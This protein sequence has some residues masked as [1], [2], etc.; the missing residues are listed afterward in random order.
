M[1]FFKHFTDNH[2]GRTVQR[3]LDEMGPAG[4]MAYYFIME[5]CAEKLEKKD[6]KA[7]TESDCVFVFNRRVIENVTRMKRKSTDKLGIIGQECSVWEWKP[8]QN[9]IIIKMPILLDLL[10]RDLKSART[11]R[12]RDAENPRLELELES[13][14][15][16]DKEICAVSPPP[17]PSIKILEI[18]NQGKGPLPDVKTFSDERKRRAKIQFSKY[19]DLDHWREVIMRWRNSTFCLEQ[20]RPN[21][22][23]FLNEKIRIKTLEG[24]YDNRDLSRRP[25]IFAVPD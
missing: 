21:F 23:D 4:V 11:R 10:D 20:W 18:W 16:I 14:L 22:D 3:F 7:A 25:A 1:R 15:D 9:E 2:R 13:E 19:P 24:K 5:I 17:N 8:N 12:A 6:G